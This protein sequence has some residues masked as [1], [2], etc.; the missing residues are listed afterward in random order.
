MNNFYEAQST[1]KLSGM[2]AIADGLSDF[3][4]CDETIDALRARHPE[5]HAATLEWAKTGTFEGESDLHQLVLKV[6][7]RVAKDHG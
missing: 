5:V 3:K 1:E 6:C 2:L 7:S 4:S